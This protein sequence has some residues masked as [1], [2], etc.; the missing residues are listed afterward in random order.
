[1]SFKRFFGVVLSR[2]GVIWWPLTIF[3]LAWY[4]GT[5]LLRVR[6]FSRLEI[7]VSSLFLVISYQGIVFRD[8][9]KVNSSFLTT[10]F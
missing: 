6:H 2:V 7:A 10:S 5:I 3:A 9:E 8:W 1:M 4:R